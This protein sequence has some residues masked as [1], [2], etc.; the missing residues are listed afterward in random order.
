MQI[1][2]LD[3]VFISSTSKILISLRPQFYLQSKFVSF[4]NTKTQIKWKTLPAIF[5]YTKH[6]LKLSTSF[7]FSD[8]LIGSLDLGPKMCGVSSLLMTLFVCAGANFDA[9]IQEK[10]TI[11]QLLKDLNRG[12]QEAKIYPLD[13]WYLQLRQAT[14]LTGRR[15]L[16][17][18]GFHLSCAT[19]DA[20][21]WNW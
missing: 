8:H 20:F 17:A 12:S 5:L 1:H 18:Q 19:G 16:V 10:V 7:S 13:D 9:Y 3:N 2:V 15:L 4:W 21:I 14:A 6:N 11:H